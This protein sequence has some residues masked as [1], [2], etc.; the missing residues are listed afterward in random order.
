M[1]STYY[2]SNGLSVSTE[3]VHPTVFKVHVSPQTPVGVYSIPFVASLLIQTTSSKLPKFNNTVTGFVDPEFQLSKKYP[4]L[5]D[6]T[7][8]ANLT[9]DVR[10][11][12]TFNEQ[13]TAFWG[14]YGDFVALLGAGAVGSVSTFLIDHLKSRKDKVK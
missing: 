11:P 2:S 3:R 13:F 12:L 1:M 7:G 4:T 14:S 6:I 10:M 5:G 8:N 9:V